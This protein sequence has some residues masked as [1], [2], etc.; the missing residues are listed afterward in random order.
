MLWTIPGGRAAERAGA[1]GLEIASAASARP[2]QCR[3]SMRS[4]HVHW[5]PALLL[6]AG[7]LLFGLWLGGC[8]ATVGEDDPD[9]TATL[10]DEGE[11]W[12]EGPPADEPDA[13]GG[14]LDEELGTTT[15]ELSGAP[16]YQLPFPCGQ[17]WA[18]QTR[19]NHSPLRSIDFNRAN[20]IGDPVLAAAAGTVSVVRNEGSTSYGRWIELDHG[21]GHRTRYAHLSTQEVSVGQRVSQ[22]QRIGTVGSTGGSSGPHLHYEQRQN[23]VAVSPV[24]D[25]SGALFYGTRNY[26]SKNACGGGTS[27]GGGSGTAT[28]RVS[29]SGA[30]LTVRSGPG[31]GYAAVGSLPNGTRVTI[32]CQV[33]G[34]SVSGTY[35]TSSLWDHVGTGYVADTYVY[36]GSDGAVAPTCR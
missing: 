15:L 2:L 33:R 29:T 36:T 6:V 21:G 7:G 27:G 32:R 35:G 20:D 1:C 9:P 11:W 5:A 12:D 34:Q 13:D 24:F 31:T 8:A 25:G 28:G 30:A 16:R 26:T 18:G 19:T 4:L 10:A 3:A 22:G 14:P 23:G 17:V